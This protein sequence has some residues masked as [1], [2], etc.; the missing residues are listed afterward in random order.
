MKTLIY[1]IW[2]F[3]VCPLLQNFSFRQVSTAQLVK[4]TVIVHDQIKEI[5][6]VHRKFASFFKK[7]MVTVVF[8]IVLK[9]HIYKSRKKV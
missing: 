7:K 6:L 9:K 2:C 1:L 8:Q 3:I 5:S 4:A